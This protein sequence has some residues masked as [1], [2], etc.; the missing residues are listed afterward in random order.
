M[1]KKEK[2]KKEEKKGKKKENKEEEK[3]EKEKE[4]KF[5]WTDERTGPTKGSTNNPVTRVL[6]RCAEV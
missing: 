3:K 4:K 6:Y 5:L 2:K 1:E